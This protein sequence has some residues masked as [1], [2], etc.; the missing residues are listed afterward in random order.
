MIR[1]SSGV[2]YSISNEG[3]GGHPSYNSIVKVSYKGYLTDDSVFDETKTPIEFPL[4]NLIQGWQIGI[5][6]LQ[7]SGRGKFIIPSD[8]GYGSTAHP[9]I[10]SSSVLI[11]DI[12]LVDFE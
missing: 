11:F 7:K 4:Y 3:Y 5:P 10:P 6:L 8:Y 2:Y 1:H 9:G 12:T